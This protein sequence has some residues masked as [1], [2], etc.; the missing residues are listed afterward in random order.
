VL[1]EIPFL[2]PPPEVLEAAKKDNNIGPAAA[3]E[4]DVDQMVAK[5]L[6]K[7]TPQLQDLL[8]QGVLKPIVQNV[9]ENEIKKK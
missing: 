4:P 8:S 6:E 5:V 3:A 2:S 1:A 7:L 9:L